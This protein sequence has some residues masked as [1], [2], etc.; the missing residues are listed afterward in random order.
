M[1]EINLAHSLDLNEKS[2]FIVCVCSIAQSCPILCDPM[3]IA[4]QAPLSMGFLRQKYWSGVPLPSPGDRPKPGIELASPVAP[5]LA[6]R[7]LK[8]YLFKLCWFFIAVWAFSQLQEAG[9]SLWSLVL[10]WSTDSTVEVCRLCCS[11]SQTRDQTC[12]SCIGTEWQRNVP[13]AVKH[14]Y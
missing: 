2:C 4:C 3:D 11:Y 12:V 5:A 14:Q 1:S 8:N 9:F 13:S 7:F 10:L 6:Y